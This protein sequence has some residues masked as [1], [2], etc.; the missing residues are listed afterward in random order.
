M[1]EKLQK[2][3]ICVAGKNNIAVAVLEYLIKNCRDRYEL[4]I[5]CNKNESGQNTWQKSL[6]FYARKNGISEYKLEEIYEIQNLIFISLEFDSIIRPERF[7]D[8]RLYNIHFSLLPQYKGMYTSAIPILNDEEYVGVT[9]H[10]IDRGIDTGDIIAQKKFELKEIYTSRDLYAQYI[11]N[12]TQLVLEHIEAVIENHVYA[13][14]QSRSNS[15]YYSK[16]YIDYTDLKIDLRQTADM[17]KRQIRAF[18]FREYQLPVV[19]GHPIIA[20]EI[21]DTKSVKKPGTVLVEEEHGMVVAAI[22]YNV[23]LY[24]DRFQELLEACRD[25]D[26]AK[27]KDICVVGAHINAANEKGWTPLI[28]ATYNNHLEIVRYL[29][30]N[31]AD[32]HARSNNGTNLLMYA[33]DAYLNSGSIDLFRLFYEMGIDVREQDYA[34]N[35]LAFYLGKVG[36]TVEDLINACT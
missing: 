25:G 36:L 18:S 31:G 12:G 21:T 1:S 28:V 2:K 5:V 8:A 16:A 20:A 32:L 7:T 3:F 4:G 29:L 19:Y 11:S 24:F 10:K 6:R 9:F 30:V 15:S 35:D 13:V 22:D 26:L 34:G 14:P 23:V 27:V 33:K 17:I